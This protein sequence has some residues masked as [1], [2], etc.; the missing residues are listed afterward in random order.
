MKPRSQNEAE[1][2]AIEEEA[3]TDEAL[4]IAHEL[5]AKARIDR[6]CAKY[7]HNR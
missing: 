6:M 4:D 2:L 3:A 5:A 7:F 1:R